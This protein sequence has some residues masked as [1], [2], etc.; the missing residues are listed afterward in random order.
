VNRPRRVVV[1]DDSRLA[2]PSPLHA[3]PSGPLAVGGDLAPERL[4]LAYRSG[5][6]PWPLLG[7]EGPMLWFS[8]DPRLVLYPERFRVSRS[9]RRE[10]RR[11]TYEVRVDTRFRDV[12]IGCA[13]RR[14]GQ[15]GTWIT[16]P[17]V[18]AYERLHHL[19]YAHSVESYRAGE[20]VGG[21]YGVAV[22]GAFFGESMFA[23]RSNASK[24]A[25]VHLVRCLD[26]WGHAFVDCQQAT[27]HLIRFGAEEIPRPRFL[28][29]LD[30]ALRLRGRPGSWR[31]R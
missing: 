6:F 25:L 16:E 20:L 3:D 9:L 8:P 21:L 12:L 13:G 7:V 5:I 17:L 19:G 28:R 10:I 1:L 29:E 14:R 30:D 24:V 22:G 2:F 27:Q 15:S 18:D 31:Q 11:G 4:L 23:R 26:R